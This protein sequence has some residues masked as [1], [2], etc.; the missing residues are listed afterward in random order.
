[1]RFHEVIIMTRIYLHTYAGAH[2]SHEE[3]NDELVQELCGE[4][5]VQEDASHSL[6][7]RMRA[8]LSTGEGAT[9]T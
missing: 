9:C 1:M 5:S 8:S 4:E 3:Q 2:E 7:H 6:C